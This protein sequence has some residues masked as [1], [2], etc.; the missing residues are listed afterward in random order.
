MTPD[1]IIERLRPLHG[2]RI[3]DVAC[4]FGD[5]LKLLAD[6]F[7]DF[8]E[9]VGIDRLD[10]VDEAGRKYP[11]PKLQYRKMDAERIEYADVYFDTVAMRH[12][13][14]HLTHP[15]KVFAEMARVLKT[16]GLF[17]LGEVYRD[18]ATERPNSQ[19]HLHHFWAEVDRVFDIP[20][21][22]TVSRA[23]IVQLV[24]RAGLRTKEVI[25]YREEATEA[26]TRESLDAMLKYT[27]D[28]I[29]KLRAAGGH[30]KLIAK[31]RELVERFRRGGYTD[32]NMVYIL[33]RK[34]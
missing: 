28:Q 11:D 25:D 16:G 3:L 10:R 23:E 18:P 32:E 13:L 24:E 1:P 6:S 19:R 22:D 30:E 34:P 29:E 8:T 31:G 15:D 7:H 4:G 14:H 2:G 33:A 12:S 9:A 21:Y 5:F 17:I 20:H 27:S 26:E